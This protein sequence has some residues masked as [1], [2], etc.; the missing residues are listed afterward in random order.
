MGKWCEN[1]QVGILPDAVIWKVSLA[2]T[3]NNPVRT[4]CM[5][6]NRIRIGWDKYGSEIND[7]T[8]WSL[9]GGEGKGILDAFINKMKI[10]L[11]DFD[12]L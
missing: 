1:K 5:N 11:K 7:E 9:M 8:D 6:N 12:L 2:G 3:G 10:G 4:D